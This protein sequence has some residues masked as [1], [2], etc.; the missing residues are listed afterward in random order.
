MISAL[1]KISQHPSVPSAKSEIAAF[2]IVTPEVSSS[3]KGEKQ[4]ASLWDS[5]PSIEERI[6]ALSQV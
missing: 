5:H 1:R 2:F 3:L 4:K 6:K